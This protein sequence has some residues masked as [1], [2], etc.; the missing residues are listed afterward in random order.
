MSEVYHKLTSKG[1]YIQL[2]EGNGIFVIKRNHL[3][4]ANSNIPGLA[5]QA[6]HKEI[7]KDDAPF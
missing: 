3:E 1:N 4:V 7:A 5:H 6:Y 2:F